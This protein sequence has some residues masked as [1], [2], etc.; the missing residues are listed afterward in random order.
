[1]I[2]SFINDY[3]SMYKECWGVIRSNKKGALGALI[4]YLIALVAVS[5]AAIKISHWWFFDRPA[6]RKEMS[7]ALRVD[8]EE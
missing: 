4:A 2:R 6:A 8:D 7:E 1:M 5:Y 3:S